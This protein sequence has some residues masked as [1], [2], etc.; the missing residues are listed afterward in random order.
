MMNRSLL[1]AAVAA[2]LAASPASADDI[3]VGVLLGF[4]GPIESLTPAMADSAELA[5]KEV[6]DSGLLLGGKRITPVRADS[7]CVDATSA[8]TAAERLVTADRVAAIYGADCSGVTTAVANNVAV[9]NG[10]VMVSPSAT[11][12]GLSSR[13][14]RHPSAQAASASRQ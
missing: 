9:P 11:S 1:C 8:V 12:P 6:S 3:K 10:V 14:P 4:T 2:C 13:Q 7:T 5:F